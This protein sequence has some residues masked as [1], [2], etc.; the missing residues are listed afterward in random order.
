MS[1][2]ISTICGSGLALTAHAVGAALR[3]AGTSYMVPGA[4]G[5][6]RGDVVHLPLLV[7]RLRHE[8][9]ERVVRRAAQ[10]RHQHPFGLTDQV[11]RRQRLVELKM[12]YRR[13]FGEPGD[14]RSMVHIRFERGGKQ[15]LDLFA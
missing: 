1:Q 14:L 5:D 2:S 10:H 4:R 13:D 6:L 15:S 9:P 8:Q 11:S 3:V 7:L 12:L